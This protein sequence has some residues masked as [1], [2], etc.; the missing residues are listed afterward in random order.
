MPSIE[1][2]IEISKQRTDQDYRE[3]HEWIDEPEHKDE[4]HDITKIPN[5]FQMF[6]DKYGEEAA[7]E[8]VQHLA[9][10][11]NGKFGHLIEDVQVLI[12]KNLVYFGAKK[13]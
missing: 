1:K 4:R 3:I 2:H 9:D 13:K 7:R 11:L 5:T 6:K 10:D 8:Y 12:D